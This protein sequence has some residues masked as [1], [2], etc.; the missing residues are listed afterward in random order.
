MTLLEA[1]FL[2]IV[3]GITE[4]LPISSSGHLVLGQHYLGINVPGNMFEI[5]VHLGT[6]ISVIVVFRRDLSKLLWSLKEK[7]TQQYILTIILGT[8]PAVF[9]GLLFKDRII[10]IFDNVQMVSLALIV[11][12]IVLLSTRLMSSKNVPLKIGS[13]IKI[14]L[15]Q[16]AAIIPGISRSGFTIAAGLILGM[17]REEIAKFSFLLSIPA[18][19]GA[20]ILTLIDI[21]EAGS[22]GLSF[23]ILLAGFFMSFLVGVGALYWL[24]NWLKSGKFYWFGIYCLGL[25]LITGIL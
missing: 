24:L 14:G 5:V 4:F 9:A 21:G 11:T 23:P 1:I 16:A 20:G 12:G 25:G 13:G 18:V 2:G 22:S 7:N 10:S 3:Q 8:L 6:M 15:A 19:T 17:R